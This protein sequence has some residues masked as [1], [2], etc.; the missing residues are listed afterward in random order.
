MP[1]NRILRTWRKPEADQRV[2]DA[3]DKTC[4]GIRERAIQI[5]EEI[6]C[7]PH[8]R[9][10]PSS[11][12]AGRRSFLSRDSS[13][14]QL[15]ARFATEA[16]AAAYGHCSERA[17]PTRS[18]RRMASC[19]VQRMIAGPQS[20]LPPRLW[21]P[22]SAQQ[23][24]WTVLPYYKDERHCCAVSTPRAAYERKGARLCVV[25]TSGLSGL[26]KK[27]G[28]RE[29][30]LI[31]EWM[32]WS[33]TQSS[34]ALRQLC[35]PSSSIAPSDDPAGAFRNHGQR[36]EY[37]ANETQPE[38]DNARASGQYQSDGYP[39]E[40][41]ELVLFR[42]RAVMQLWFHSPQRQRGGSPFL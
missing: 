28:R 35:L 21:P 15:L 36:Y 37:C 2:M 25:G 18:H 13:V 29:L 17:A 3:C 34:S 6:R 14:L 40:L 26:P 1:C 16:A 19:V 20:T 8:H 39:M 22:G 10:L 5:Q 38:Q 30:S 12:M 33:V 24:A 32:S 9:V 41:H 42:F 11:F 23:S 27:R 31:P 7:S 4:S